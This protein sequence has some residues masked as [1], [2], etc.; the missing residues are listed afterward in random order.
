MKID[1]L[2]LTEDD[3]LASTIAGATQFKLEKETNPAIAARALISAAE[4]RVLNKLERDALKDYVDTFVIMITN[5][6]LRGRLKDIQRIA[7][8]MNPKELDDIKDDS[9]KDKD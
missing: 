6:Q 2:N 1:D 9:T 3:K 4:G 8:K 5:Q 7:Q